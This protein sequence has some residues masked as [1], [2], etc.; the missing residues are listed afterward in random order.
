MTTTPG[1]K[2]RTTPW[3][4]P[5][6]AKSMGPT[7]G[8]PGSCRPQMGPMLAQEPCYQGWLLIRWLLVCQNIRSHPTAYAGTTILCLIWRKVPTTRAHPRV[9]KSWKKFTYIIPLRKLSIASLIG[10]LHLSMDGIFKK[11]VNKCLRR[12]WQTRRQE[13]S[14]YLTLRDWVMHSIC[15]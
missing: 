5:Q 13:I 9:D 1:V 4:T 6:L 15:A 2:T 12:P 3:I 14:V 10:A 11:W 8:P 7:W